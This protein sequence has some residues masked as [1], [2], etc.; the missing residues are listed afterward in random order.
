MTKSDLPV[1]TVSGRVVRHQL[2]DTTIS[3]THQPEL[4]NEQND[5]PIYCLK[6]V[7][8]FKLFLINIGNGKVITQVWHV[9]A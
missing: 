9:A 5:F 1:Q 7:N 3:F 6:R 2:T 8:L 4:F